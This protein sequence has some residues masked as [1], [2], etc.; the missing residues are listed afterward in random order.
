MSK[1]L[2]QD[3]LLSLLL[4]ATIAVLYTYPL[5]FQL[6][7]VTGGDGYVFLHAFWWFKKAV[8][9]LR[10]PFFTDY[11]LYPDG[12][13]LAF[14]SSTF[15]N[16]LITLPISL[17]AGANSAVNSAYILGYVIS[18][19]AAFLLAFE[20]TG[21]KN[22]AFIAG[23]IYAFNPF[24]FSHGASHLNISTIQ[25]LPLYLLMFKYTME[26]E[27]KKWPVFAGLILGGIILTDQFQTILAALLTLVLLPFMLFRFTGADD[28]G[29]SRVPGI[30]PEAGKEWS[31]F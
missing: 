30:R 2:W 10:N 12:V 19:Y 28:A 11:L 31:A 15:S 25:W 6:N 23:L 14:Q 20:L 26:R 17:F 21:N 5:V 13:S 7:S 22:S 16:F 3:H 27:K 24:H 29:A 9:S 4:F 8:L 1:L 18:G